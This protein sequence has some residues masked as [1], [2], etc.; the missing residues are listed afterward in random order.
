VHVDPVSKRHVRLE[1]KAKEVE[2]RFHSDDDGSEEDEESEDKE[3]DNAYSD[4]DDDG[5]EEENSTSNNN[6]VDDLSSVLVLSESDPAFVMLNDCVIDL[7]TICDISMSIISDSIQ[8][9]DSS[10]QLALALLTLHWISICRAEV[11]A[12]SKTFA[13]NAAKLT[14]LIGKQM[15]SISATP[16]YPFVVRVLCQ[17]S[18]V[19][20]EFCS[21]MLVSDCMVILVDK[22]IEDPLSMSRLSA[23]IACIDFFSMRTD[24][25]DSSLLLSTLL[26]ETKAN[27]LLAAMIR[28]SCTPSYWIRV[29]ILRIVSHLPLVSNRIKADMSEE[30]Q[31]KE[32]KKVEID[33]P[34][35]CLEASALPASLNS[36]RE[37]ARKVGAVEAFIRLGLASRDAICL[38]ASFSLGVLSYKFKPF[39]QPAVNV[40]V[41]AVDNTPQEDQDVV[42]KLILDVLSKASKTS[43][44]DESEV[45]NQ[46][47][48]GDE[49]RKDKR[50]FHEILTGCLHE[51][52]MLDNGADQVPVEVARSVVFPFLYYHPEEHHTMHVADLR[53]DLDARVDYNTHYMT[54][55]SVFKACP[56]LTM[57]R[58]KIVV[59]MFLR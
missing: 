18:H 56:N 42:W 8:S 36:E 35:L 24:I 38:A 33:I 45:D 5:A 1:K 30:N 17:L 47:S 40:L 44:P 48:L 49:G 10:H 15:S 46:D 13:S 28:A 53:V 54:L 22:L 7:I 3:S 9:S 4:N 6:F 57:Q 50:P 27:Q 21:K 26:G 2:E 52:S 20:N 43:P 39:W 51:L 11:L 55:W 34:A 16:S 14:K 31:E 37:Y 23:L 32:E 59:P 12:L 19:N 58:S 29:C 25:A 41:A